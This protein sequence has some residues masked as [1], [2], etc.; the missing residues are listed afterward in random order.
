M[1]T[2]EKTEFH[3]VRLDGEI[4][5][6]DQKPPA[7]R[8]H[9]SLA[10]NHSSVN[11]LIATRQSANTGEP[12]PAT[13]PPLEDQSTREDAPSPSIDSRALGV[14]FS[15]PAP[16]A[17]A[18]IAVESMPET[19]EKCEETVEAQADDQDASHEEAAQPDAS[20]STPGPELKGEPETE[21][22]R[23]IETED[24]KAFSTELA[25]QLSPEQT[26][27][28]SPLP[29]EAVAPTAEQPA[30]E[31]LP[32]S[33]ASLSLGGE[34]DNLLH[35]VQHTLDSLADMAK[36]LTQQKLDALKHQ[37]SLEQRRTQLQDKERLLADK[38]E[39]L[40]LLEARLTREVGNLE[41]SAEDNARALAERSAALKSLAENVEAR[42]RGTTRLAETLRTEKQRNDELT[43]ALQ[44]RSDAL[45]ERG[46]S[47]DRKE[48]EL[49]E[50][51]KQLIAAK[52]RFRALV[53]AFNE[54]VQFN[55]TLNAISSTALDDSH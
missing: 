13:R 1:S 52:D 18:A 40:R 48:D 17:E 5:G 19:E 42:D 3:F 44:R 24:L 20:D 25:T 38:E 34:A 33:S 32:P 10:I 28:A 39:Q 36:G 14:D 9:R 51:L 47:L 50:N 30:S 49:A 31:P 22:P 55:D 43:D 12:L 53:K 8:E 35:D 6:A 46:A 45:D 29:L 11:K 21:S 37:E 54:T 4:T 27:P 41:R 15:L 16:P 7:V 23:R 2:T 26:D